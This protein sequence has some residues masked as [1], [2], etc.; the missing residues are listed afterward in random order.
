MTVT[1]KE[2]VCQIINDEP[3]G[4]STN[5]KSAFLLLKKVM[6]EGHIP[7]RQ[8]IVIFGSDG[9]P[10]T[11]LE[12]VDEIR[13]LYNTD[14]IFQIY[15]CSFGGSVS[16]TV[17]QSVLKINN[18]ENY[19]HF[20]E[21]NQFQYFIKNDLECD[22]PIIASNV[23]IICKNVIPLSSQTMNREQENEYEINIDILKSIDFLSFPLEFIDFNNFEIKITYK[24]TNNENLELEC[25]E[26]QMD[27]NFIIHTY[28]SKKIIHF[29]YVQ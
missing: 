25:L 10:D 18:Q 7:G 1:I 13:D 29:I 6:V 2:Q 12:G 15:S 22:N 11:L 8:M 4:G 26:V 9:I 27:N 21:P 14:M 23:K 19:R 24:N 17:L 3:I 5:Y 16:A 28:N 20:V